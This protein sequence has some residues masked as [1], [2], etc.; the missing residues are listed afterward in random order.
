MPDDKFVTFLEAEAAPDNLTILA[1]SDKGAKEL[2]KH[3]QDR[4]KSLSSSYIPFNNPAD[5]CWVRAEEM[6]TDPLVTTYSRHGVPFAKIWLATPGHAFK[7]KAISPNSTV[8]IPAGDY[9]VSQQ[10]QVPQPHA[11]PAPASA[12]SK[13]HFGVPVHGQSAGLGLVTWSYH[14]ALISLVAG[15]NGKFRAVVFDPSL[16]NAPLSPEEWLNLTNCG[17]AYCW[18]MRVKWY[19]PDTNNPSSKPDRYAWATVAEVA[20]SRREQLKA[21][22]LNRGRPT[23][24][25][26]DDK[27]LRSDWPTINADIMNHLD[28]FFSPLFERR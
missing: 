17:N 11:Q 18:P 27:F 6:A 23:Q 7:L 8:P 3:F 24:P 25:K 20:K 14:V 4:V 16:A 22:A 28:E 9:Y 12:V 10:F 26:T 2:F 21:I 13:Q 5:F 15:S 1:L 19:S